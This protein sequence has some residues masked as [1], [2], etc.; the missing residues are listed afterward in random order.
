MAVSIT[1]TAFHD[2]PYLANWLR[3]GDDN[4]IAAFNQIG[5][6]V[7]RNRDAW[8]LRIAVVVIDAFYA[9]V[10]L[11]EADYHDMDVCLSA[12]FAFPPEGAVPKA[13]FDL[14]TR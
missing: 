9:G 6:N 10:S 8:N 11:T 12:C 14:M 1:G 2:L 5:R 13:D 4:H 3:T 7:P